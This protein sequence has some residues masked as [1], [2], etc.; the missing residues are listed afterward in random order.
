GGDDVRGLPPFAPLAAEV[1]G[2]GVGG[3]EEEGVVVER[4]ARGLGGDLEDGL[5]VEEEGDGAGGAEVAAVL[6]EEAAEV[7]HG[8]VRVVRERLDED[9]DAAG[10]VALVRHL[11]VVGPLDLAGAPLDGALDGVLRH[12]LRLRLVDGEGEA[13][14]RVGVAAALARRDHEVARDAG[15]RLRAPLVGGALLPLDLRPLVVTGHRVSCSV[16]WGMPSGKD[17]GGGGP[18]RARRAVAGAPLPRRRTGR[19]GTMRRAPTAPRRPTSPRPRRRRR[20]G[21]AA[22]SPRPRT[23]GWARRGRGRRRRTSSRRGPRPTRAPR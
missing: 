7:G 19:R 8:P 18:R 2:A 14:V 20:G 5:L 12:V 23:R 10:A 3:E 4:A 22:A 1:L 13:G 16:R 11:L 9:G 21:G 15:P 17:T 6:R